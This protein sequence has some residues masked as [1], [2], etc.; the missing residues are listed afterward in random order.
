MYTYRWCHEWGIGDESL[1]DFIKSLN[2]RDSIE[3]C[4]CYTG[5]FPCSLSRIRETWQLSSSFLSL[6]SPTE[7]YSQHVYL[8]RMRRIQLYWTVAGFGKVVDWRVLVLPS[9]VWAQT[10]HVHVAQKERQGVVCWRIHTEIHWDIRHVAINGYVLAG[11]RRRR[12]SFAASR[13]DATYDQ[14]G[15]W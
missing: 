15:L 10:D 12:N 7:W 2:W 5:Y 11:W 14:V 6:A 4:S 13:A 9:V 8:S 3:N 1:V